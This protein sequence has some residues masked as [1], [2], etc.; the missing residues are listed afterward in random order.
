MDSTDAY[1]AG[2]RLAPLTKDGEAELGKLIE[3]GER[4]IVQALLEADAGRRAIGE[5]RDDV[6]ARRV[7]LDH[8]LR[9]VTDEKAQRTR[10]LRALASPSAARLVSIRLHPDLLE[11]L[12]RAVSDPAILERVSRAKQQI[13]GAKAKLVEH[14]LRLVVSFARRYRNDHLGLLD[15]IQEG[16]LGLMR[17]VDKFDYHR[18]FRLSTYAGWWIRQAIERAITERA[19]TIHVPVHLIESRS[20]LMR[21]RDEL[22]R[23]LEREPTPAQLSAHSGLPLDKVETILSLVREPIS[24]DLPV[25]EDG[26]ARLI[27]L[28]ANELVIN[29]EEDVAGARTRA[30]ARAL[31]MTLSPRERDIIEKHFGLDGA[32]PRTLEQIGAELSLTRERIRQIEQVALRKLRVTSLAA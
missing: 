8:V 14:N 20:K 30:D 27:D 12:V 1:L 32:P 21:A 28:I 16:N 19:P 9:N 24:L 7:A 15:L 6:R 31:L 11:Q 18:G 17:A 23:R 4:S 22:H 5:L 29:P 26:D 25:G 2:L 3:S 10:L 13:K